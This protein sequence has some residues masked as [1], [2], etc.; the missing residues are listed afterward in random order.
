MPFWPL[1]GV[2]PPSGQVNVFGPVVGGED[3]DRVVGLADLVQVLQEGADAVV[4]LRHAGLFQ[5][6][7]GLAV[8]HRT[9][10]LREERPDVH[11]RR[12]VPDEEW[13]A[14]LLGLVHELAGRLDE[15]FVEGRHVVLRLEERHVVHVGHVGHVRE[16]RQRA[17]ID[18]FLLAD[19]A[20][21]RHYRL[22]VGIG[23]IAM[24]QAARAVLVVVVL[25]QSGTSTSTGSDM[26]SRWYR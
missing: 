3:D 25:V 1:N 7:V 6:V 16:R 14:V 11:P 2:L 8:L 5:A 20:P 12:V 19:L 23:R 18:D 21:A 15:H 9:V 17:F 22:V 24:D 4:H 26:A 10:F 13:L